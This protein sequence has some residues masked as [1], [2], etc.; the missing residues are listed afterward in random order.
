[1][2]ASNAK[3]DGR[4]LKRL[5]IVLAIL[6]FLTAAGFVYELTR[7][8]RG[9][10]SI[11]SMIDVLIGRDWDVDQNYDRLYQ[12]SITYVE[13]PADADL[14]GKLYI[15]PEREA[16]M[17]DMTLIVPKLE[18]NAPVGNGTTLPVLRKGPALF[19]FASLP[20]TGD[21][22]VAIAGHREGGVFFYLD[23]LE[24][25][26]NI[27]LIYKEKVFRYSYKDTKAV[28]PSDW[29]VISG[30]GFPCVTLVTC[31]PIGIADHRMIVRGELQEMLDYSEAIEFS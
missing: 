11:D 4:R 8:Y 9:Q 16:Y 10:N 6:I 31:T 13:M 15:T 27:Y 1:M 25:G 30:Q 21:R 18:V 19:D 24:E 5:R 14:T 7:P 12:D 2:A 20:G 29:S 3:G 17:E 22:N 23:R 26:D 28:L